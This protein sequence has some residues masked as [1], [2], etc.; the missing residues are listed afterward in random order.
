M[1]SI[2]EG[3]TKKIVKQLM[4]GMDK[5]GEDYQDIS[6]DEFKEVFN[7]DTTAKNMS[8]IRNSTTIR[9]NE[10]GPSNW[11]LKVRI[12]KNGKIA[13]VTRYPKIAWEYP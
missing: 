4:E 9:L 8:N 6:F 2:F 10:V 3:I 13:R 11:Y 1:R 7:I 12:R 5:D